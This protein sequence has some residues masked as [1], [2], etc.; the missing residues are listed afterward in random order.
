MSS[1][2]TVREYARLTTLEVNNQGP[3]YA[4][5]PPSLFDWLCR[6][7][8]GYRTQHSPILAEI[9]DRRTLFLDNYVGI[10]QSPCGTVLEVLPK[11]H[12]HGDDIAASRQL[13]KEMIVMSLD[14]PVREAGITYLEQFPLP[15]NDW[16]A[17]QFLASLNT[18]MK[19]GV[20]SDY[21][22]SEHYEPYLRGQLD[23]VRQ[24]RQ[25]AGKAHLF[26]LRYDI[27]SPD[28][29]ENRLIVS[30]LQQVV[31]Y[32]KNPELWRL[33][34]ELHLT[35]SK[36]PASKNINGDLKL[37]YEDRLMKHYQPVKPWCELILAGQ[38]PLAIKGK[39]QGISMLF[40][41]EKLFERCVETSLRLQL[42]PGTQF[43]SQA[44]RYSLC[45][46][47]SENLFQLRPDIL[48]QNGTQ[49]WVLDAKW[50]RLDERD[51]QSKYSLNQA[52]FYQMYAYGQKY[53]RGEGDMALIYPSYDGFQTP[54]P[55]F[56]FDEKLRL[57]VLPFAVTG[58][59]KGKVIHGGDTSLPF[60]T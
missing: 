29:A 22:R 8:A 3:D 48:L 13:L 42:K 5:I 34:R 37:W 28:R 36:I 50:K 59:N 32:T 25:P 58:I 44:R 57:W 2:I 16:V 52:D 35:L 9:T 30:A 27:F 39:T 55:V 23:V 53:M 6:L 26:H 7:S 33:A 12:E 4:Q 49:Y 56:N 1:I 43:T 18:L 31:R 11:I 19:R 40:P 47:K 38:M 17:S 21:L 46:H 54:L 24:M 20:R 10:L 41:M 15:L 60:D 45:V 51:S 14:M